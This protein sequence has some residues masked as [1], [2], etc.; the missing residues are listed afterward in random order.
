[1]EILTGSTRLK[2]GTAQKMCLNR[3]STGAMVLNGKVIENL[4]VDVRAK[5]IKLRD[6]CVRIL[7]ELSTATRD[8]AQDAL[9]ANEWS[10][11]DALESL[12]TPA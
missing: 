6:R 1:P 7:C 12:Q 5:N 3:I 11:R 8:E 10:I 9:E 4:M 2:A